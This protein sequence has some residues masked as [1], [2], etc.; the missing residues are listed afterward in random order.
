MESA[1]AESEQMEY[2]FAELYKNGNAV[3]L[4][5]MISWDKFIGTYRCGDPKIRNCY[6]FVCKLWGFHNNDDNNMRTLIFINE[7]DERMLH[8]NNINGK[9]YTCGLVK[10]YCSLLIEM[11]DAFEIF[12][13]Y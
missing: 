2:T 1:G 12:Q 3:G 9:L 7:D 6:N 4:N 8:V 11:P 10:D 13:Q 5:F